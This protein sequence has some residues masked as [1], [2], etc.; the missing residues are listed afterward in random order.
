MHTQ[1][2]QLGSTYLQDILQIFR[3]MSSNDGDIHLS[4]S[5]TQAHAAR[6]V[7]SQLDHNLCS[8]KCFQT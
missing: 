5:H 8:K 6:L 7:Y 2:Q 3:H 1:Q 4:M